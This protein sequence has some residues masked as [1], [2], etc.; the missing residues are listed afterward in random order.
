[1]AK[2]TPAVAFKGVS[3]GCYFK[4]GMYI[5]ACAKIDIYNQANTT[6]INKKFTA[7]L[8]ETDPYAYSEVVI[9]ALSLR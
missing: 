2:T 9:T 1:V 6:C 8:Y 7:D 4:A 3:G 5:Q